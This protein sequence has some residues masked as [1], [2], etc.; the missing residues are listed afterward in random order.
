MRTL[1]KNSHC[2]WLLTTIL[3]VFFHVLPASANQNQWTESVTCTRYYDMHSEVLYGNNNP[4]YPN[5]SPCIR[6]YV[7][8]VYQG[9]KVELKIDYNPA[10][11]SANVNT[12]F[13]GTQNVPGVPGSTYDFTGTSGYAPGLGDPAPVVQFNTLGKNIVTFTYF[14]TLVNMYVQELILEFE[15]IPKLDVWVEA[16][17]ICPQDFLNA[18]QD[19]HFNIKTSPVSLNTFM[20]STPVVPMGDNPSGGCYHAERIDVGIESALGSMVQGVSHLYGSTFN[21]ATAPDPVD[22][23]IPYS[24]LSSSL[25]PSQVGNVINLDI[26]FTDGIRDFIIPAPIV[27]K[28]DN[29][30]A[31]DPS[32]NI[33][34]ASYHFYD[35]TV[36]GDEV[37]TPTSNPLAQLYGT[38]GTAS[39]VRIQHELTIPAGATLRVQDMNVE[40]GPMARTVIKT[41]PGRGTYGGLVHLE[42]STFTAFHPCGNDD[43]LWEG[44]TVMGDNGQN[45]EVQNNSTG[46]RWQ[47]TLELVNSTIS[48][49]HEAIMA[50]DVNDVNHKSGG[51][52]QA[53]NSNFYNNCRSASFTNYHFQTGTGSSAIALPYRA[54]FSNC[55]FSVDR[56]LKYNFR[57]FISGWQVRGVWI[58]GSRFKNVS[59]VNTPYNYGIDGADFGFVVDK[60]GNVPSEFHNM[61]NAIHSDNV[62]GTAAVTVKNARFY[63]NDIA[64]NLNAVNAPVI[65]SNEINV[66]VGDPQQ[67]KIGV[68]LQGC[69]GFTV[70]DNVLQSTDAYRNTGV[71]VVNGGSASNEIKRNMF[72]NLSSGNLSNY[73][74]RT[75]VFG[76][77][78]GLQYFCNTHNNNVYDMA[79]RGSNPATDGICAQQG[80][81]QVPAEDVFNG[82]PLHQYE[83]Y[84]PEAEVGALNYNASSPAA[85]P[86][87]NLGNVTTAIGSGVNDCKDPEKPTG[88]GGNGSSQFAQQR[89]GQLMGYSELTSSDSLYYWLHEWQ[90]PYSAL[91]NVDLL[92][93]DGNTEDASRLYN[94]I[95]G[96]YEMRGTEADEFN[97]YGRTFM[98]IRIA[99]IR[100]RKGMTDLSAD[101]IASL[102]NVAAHAS[103]WAKYRAQNWL[104]LY[105][106]R[107]FT[108]QLLFPEDGP[109]GKNAMTRKS[110]ET[111]TCKLYPNPAQGMLHVDHVNGNGAVCT[112]QLMEM[113]GRVL[114]SK[115]LPGQEGTTDIDVR[116]LAPGI[117]MYQLMDN[118]Q[119][120][121]TGKIV[122]E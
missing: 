11:A 83:I 78:F 60:L 26:H 34:A 53:D 61:K 54:R 25:S 96:S 24:I 99:H 98:D 67:Q 84:N 16:P 91:M 103:M 68:L 108:N 106:G 40:F 112:L 97:E 59:G 3:L 111:T 41:M 121:Q 32:N 75:T 85:V 94:S 101:D 12:Y 110:P 70:H 35:Y 52:V 6:T 4:T 28:S 51:V 71:L 36:Q 87:H 73:I 81:L 102:E 55:D 109:A 89:I 107:S 8:R 76:I 113:N 77:P 33:P 105:D 100:T 38:G 90:N 69:A 115:E 119:V 46:Q 18:G 122:R 20:R 7:F 42:Q 14:N 65:N 116:Q 37:W 86:T 117:Y 1:F 21:A 27:I 5:N 114:L 120:K 62:N 44:F 50:T 72:S 58:Y 10:N 19:Y 17:E 49:A 82:G 39:T 9:D 92:L 95:T 63:N 2:K 56:A 13:S 88:P 43:S 48:Y 64:I 74:N 66:P 79:A 23:Y 118:G 30:V 104:S 80:S 45:Q 57:G 29:T 47:G 93:E 15:V 22:H 31:A